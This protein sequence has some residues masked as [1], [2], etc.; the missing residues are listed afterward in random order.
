[1]NCLVFITLLAMLAVSYAFT[2]IAS[3][4]RFATHLLAKTK[5]K[6]TLQFEGKET[7]MEVREDETILNAARDNGIE[8]P[9]DCELGVCLTC[10]AKVVS[11]KVDQSGGTLDDS[12][13][14]QGYALTCVSCPRSD[15]V[16]KAI[17][18]DEL[19]SAQFKR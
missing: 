9:H 19:V 7:I 2:G 10:P 14:E 8:L 1:M 15:V 4:S 12:V 13:M 17:D 6:V 5:H 3:K 16:I 11:G 18:E